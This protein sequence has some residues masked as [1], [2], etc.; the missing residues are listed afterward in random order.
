[1][2]LSLLRRLFAEGVLKNAIIVPVPLEADRWNLILK[3]NNGDSEIISRARTDE[4]K[5]YKRVNGAII[6]AKE[7]GFDRVEIVFDK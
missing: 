6:D 2:E 3:K 5:K 1:M 4:P 7:I